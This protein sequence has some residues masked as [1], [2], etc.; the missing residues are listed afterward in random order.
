M[1]KSINQ[2][3]ICITSQC[4]LLLLSSI[5]NDNPFSLMDL[6]I[7]ASRPRTDRNE[8]TASFDV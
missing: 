8:E 3:H 4:I 5:S 7:Y 6:Y 2:K 1:L